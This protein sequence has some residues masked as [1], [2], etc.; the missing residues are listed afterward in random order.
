MGNQSF[1]QNAPPAVGTKDAWVP[2]SPD[3]TLLPPQFSL[4]SA[5]LF[6]ILKEL[7]GVP[8]KSQAYRT[9]LSLPQTMPLTRDSPPLSGIPDTKASWEISYLA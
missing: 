2:G 6:Q 3:L 1:G 7:A 5:N 8:H 9:L 4:G